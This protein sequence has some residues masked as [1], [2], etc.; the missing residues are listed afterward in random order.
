MSGQPEA[1]ELIAGFANTVDLESGRDELAG[2]EG[3]ARW[4][5]RTGLVRQAPRVTDADVQAARDLRTGIREALSDG[6]RPPS[7]HRLA[8][9]D[10]V[11]ARLPV[12]VTLTPRAA[13]PATGAP[14]SALGPSPDLA[15][16]PH[17]MA[18][19]AA[20]WAELALTGQAQRLKRCA[21][22]GCGEVFWDTSRNHS[23]RWCSM[24]VCGNRAKAR[25][26]T[27]RRTTPDGA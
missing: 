8:L 26:H 11:L 24:Q 27:A 19:L 7:P 25:R 15:P 9:G 1:A 20:A 22:Q 3:L 21:N 12:L 23:R 14:Q 6:A 16:V 13:L 18:R 2:A 5:T 17:A 10:A 4:L